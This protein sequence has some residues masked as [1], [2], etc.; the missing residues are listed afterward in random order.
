MITLQAAGNIAGVAANANSVTCTITGMELAAGNETYKVLNQ[1]NLATAAANLYAAPANTT[2]F[3]KRIFLVNTTG[4]IQSGVILYASGSGAAPTAATQITGNFSIPVNGSVVYDENGWTTYD[5]NMQSQV[6]GPAS[7]RLKSVST[8][9][10]GTV[11]YTVPAGVNAIL[12]ECIGPGGGGGGANANATNNSAYG[13]GGGAGG[14]ARKLITS[15]AANYTVA[16]GN[17]GAGGSAA[18]GN[19]V[20]GSANTTFAIPAGATV[21]ASLGAAGVGQVG[22]ATIAMVAGGAGGAAANGDVNFS[23]GAGANGG[24]FTTVI[25]TGVPTGMPG[26]GGDN[27]MGPGAKATPSGITS[28]GAAA[29]LYGGGGAGGAAN[30]SAAANGTGGAGANG[31]IFVWEYA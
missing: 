10:P 2:S 9:N 26:S 19:G 21:T 23:G 15:L 5:A 20:A 24:R 6:S 25:T 16:V 29:T 27:P 4:N 28:V 18:G 17:G 22:A 8:I 13:A 31:V 3:V 30:G 12:V 1:G 14:Y 7:G 11:T